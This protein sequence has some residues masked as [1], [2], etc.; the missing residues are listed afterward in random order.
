MPICSY[1]SFKKKIEEDNN[2]ITNITGIFAFM[3]QI[4]DS[5]LGSDKDKNLNRDWNRFAEMADKTG[6]ELS[7]NETLQAFLNEFSAFGKFLDTIEAPFKKTNFQR[8]YEAIGK[9]GRKKQDQF[10]QYMEQLNGTLELGMDL[11]A[12]RESVKGL[13]AEEEVIDDKRIEINE[14]LLEKKSIIEIGDDIIPR[15]RNGRKPQK[16]PKNPD[17]FYQEIMSEDRAN[18]LKMMKGVRGRL[19]TLAGSEEYR[20]ALGH[21][22]GDAEKL[23]RYASDMHTAFAVIRKKKKDKKDIKGQKDAE[24]NKRVEQDEVNGLRQSE[25]IADFLMAKDGYGNYYRASALKEAAFALNGSTETLYED[26]YYMNDKLNMG[27][28]LREMFPASVYPK[29]K[30]SGQPSWENYRDD[31]LIEVPFDK[32]G[33]E[34][35]LARAMVGAFKAHQQKHTG[36]HDSF[37]VK[38]ARSYAEDLMKTPL[39]KKL[40]EDQAAVNQLIHEAKNNPENLHRVATQILWPFSIVE[41]Q[42]K[43]RERA[44]AE[45]RETMTRLKNMADLM[46]GYEEKNSRWNALRKSI[47]TIDLTNPGDTGEEKLNEIFFA[48]NNYLKDKLAGSNDRALQNRI[49]QTLDILAE[50]SKCSPFAKMKVQMIFDKV[51]AA[52]A[53]RA[54]NEIDVLENKIAVDKAITANAMLPLD[55]VNEAKDNIK[56]N[57]RRVKALQSYAKSFKLIYYGADRLTKHANVTNPLALNA[58]MEKLQPSK[59][60]PLE[61]SL[62]IQPKEEPVTVFGRFPKNDASLLPRAPVGRKALTYIKLS[63]CTGVIL[64]NTFVTDDQGEGIKISKEHA[65]MAIAASLAL[66]ETK[67]YYL[68]SNKTNNSVFM[69]DNTEYEDHLARYMGDPAVQKLA[70][71]YTEPGSRKELLNKDKVKNVKMLL[72]IDLLKQRYNEVQKELISPEKKPKGPAMHH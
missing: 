72:D 16:P 26:L 24:F 31:H 14:D 68:Q 6:K 34:V 15:K 47:C 11:P 28:P 57:E 22:A 52:S 7:E 56:A 1:E 30:M 67:L 40:C 60:Q 51:K 58:Y 70:E 36:I 4:R 45:R 49:F 2:L 23:S 42:P 39:F 44:L 66:S 12:L 55:V 50:L 21:H 25:K 53:T 17:A 10:L 20:E 41:T 33:R 18:L 43:K 48:A 27:L 59:E 29:K 69:V 63:D 32:K 71:R 64:S 46:D 54:A 8:T 19:L 61:E 3:D 9:G 65:A 62:I 5:Y 13:E 35:C 38:K 37:S